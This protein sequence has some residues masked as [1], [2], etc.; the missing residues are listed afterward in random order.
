ML[1]KKNY[2]FVCEFFIRILSLYKKSKKKN[3]K[4]QDD[5]TDGKLRD[6]CASRLTALSLENPQT[7]RTYA[8]VIASI[9]TILS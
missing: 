8:D 2:I 9:V 3:C 7:K 4:H 6:A 1:S 5:I